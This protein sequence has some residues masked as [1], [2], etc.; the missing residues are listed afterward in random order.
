MTSATLAQSPGNKVLTVRQA[1]F[2][3]KTLGQKTPWPSA[4]NLI[5]ITLNSN[6]PLFGSEVRCVTNITIS[7]FDGACIS[8]DDLQVQGGIFSTVSWH[9]ETSSIL[10]RVAGAIGGPNAQ[11]I[12]FS[13]AATNP[14]EAQPSPLIEIQADGIPIPRSRMAKDSAIPTNSDDAGVGSPNGAIF[15]ASARDAEP[16][17]VHAPAFRVRNVGQSTP[18]PGANNT[19]GVTISPNVDI[20]VGSVMMIS[21]LTNTDG[22][23]AAPTGPISL[24]DGDTHP[25]GKS[26]LD[27]PAYFAASTGGA[28]GQGFWDQDEGTLTLY[29]VSRLT[30]GSFYSF[31]FILK[32]ALCAQDAQPVCIRARNLRVGC[33]VG[34]LIPR[35]RMNP[36]LTT[37]LPAFKAAQGDAAPLLVFQ[38]RIIVSS[39]IHSTPWPSVN[40][41]IT[42]TF[43]TNV[44]LLISAF[45][46]KITLSGLIQT[47]T[48]DTMSLA[49]TIQDGLGNV[50]SVSGEW[51]QGAGKLVFAPAEDMTAG[52]NYTISF[53][54]QNRHCQQDAPV[55]TAGISGACFP[56]AQM[57]AMPAT[58]CNVE[59][60]PLQVLG[61][62]CD[63]QSS[64]A[65]FTLKNI[66]QSTPYP[67]C[68]NTITVQVMMSIPLSYEQDAGIRIGFDT[69]MVIG[70]PG[71]DV[72]LGGDSRERFFGSLANET[73]KALWDSDDHILTLMV[74]QGQNLDPCVQY[75]ITFD[76]VNPLMV[77]PPGSAAASQAI[78]QEAETVHISAFSSLGEMIGASAMSVDT[79]SDLELPG[80]TILDRS[81]LRVHVPKFFVK[82]IGQSSPYPGGSNLLSV[83]I[84]ANVDLKSGSIIFIK[85]LDE[86]IAA[87]GDIALQ[88][89][90]ADFFQSL[91]GTGSHASWDDC[92]KALI[93]KV[94]T[95]LGCAGDNYTFAFEVMNPLEPQVCADVLINATEIANPAVFEDQGQP[96]KVSITQDQSYD[97]KSDGLAMALDEISLLEDID[98]AM[99]GDACPMTVWSAA[100]VVKDIG[101][102]NPYP[103][104]LNTLTAT[105]ATNVPIWASIQYPGRSVIKPSIIISEIVG[106]VRDDADATGE[107]VIKLSSTYT[108]QLVSEMSSQRYTNDTF[109]FTDQSGSLNNSATWQR[110]INR[111]AAHSQLVLYLNESSV[112]CC[113][114]GPKRL[115]VTFSFTVYNPAE[116]QSPSRAVSISAAGLPI[117]SSAMREGLDSA[118]PMHV[119]QASMT[120]AN[121]AQEHA[122]PCA[123]NTITVSLQTDIILYARCSPKILLTELTGLYESRLALTDVTTVETVNATRNESLLQWRVQ[124]T[125]IHPWQVDWLAGNLTRNHTRTMMRVQ[126]FCRLDETRTTCNQ[127]EG[128]KVGLQ[129][130][131]WYQDWSSWVYFDYTGPMPVDWHITLTEAGFTFAWEGEAHRI[132]KHPRNMQFAETQINLADVDDVTVT[133]CIE[134]P[135][136]RTS[137]TKR[138][139]IQAVNGGQPA[140]L[141]SFAIW[142]NE[143]LPDGDDFASLEVAI[144]A[145]EVPVDTVLI[146]QFSLD[147]PSD[148]TS[149]DFAPTAEITGIGM[150]NVTMQRPLDPERWPIT[151]GRAHFE[152]AEIVQSAP[153]P[154]AENTLSVTLATSSEIASTCNTR[155]IITGL[156]GACFASISGSGVVPL[157]GP[158]ANLF[159]YSLPSALNNSGHARALWDDEDKELSFFVAG[160]GLQGQIPYTFSIVVRNP[161]YAQLSPSINISATGIPIQQTA[162]LRNP[163]RIKPAGIF[164]AIPSE[165]EPLHVRGFGDATSFIVKKIGQSN[166]NPGESN[167]LTV[168][169]NMNLPLTSSSPASSITISGLRGAEAPDGPMA[170][171][172]NA[173]SFEGDWYDREKQLRLEVLAAT[174]PGQ[175]YIISFTVTNAKVA[176]SSPSVFIQTG[177]IVIQPAAMDTDDVGRLTTKDDLGNTVSTVE[178]ATAPLFILGPRLIKKFV[179]QT[180]GSAWPGQSNVLTF[181]FTPTVPLVPAPGGRSSVIISGLK[182]V[183]RQSGTVPIAGASAGKFTDCDTLNTTTCSAQQGAWD[184]VSQKLTLNVYSTL[185]AFEDLSISFSFDNA[186]EG[187]EPPDLQV[188][189]T[190]NNDADIRGLMRTEYNWTQQ[191]GG[192]HTV[193]SAQMD[194]YFVND[195]V[196][197]AQTAVDGLQD[198]STLEDGNVLTKTEG[199]GLKYEGILVIEEPGEYTFGVVGDDSTDLAVDGQV[200]ASRSDS[201]WDVT[202]AQGNPTSRTV[203]LGRGQHSFRA[204]CLQNEDGLGVKAYWK[205]PSASTAFVLIPDSAFRIEIDVLELP[206]QDFG[207]PTNVAGTDDMALLIYR[208]ASFNVKAIAQSTPIPGATNTITV[209]FQPQFPLTG[210]MNSTIT[211]SG[212]LGSV[213]PDATMALLDASALFNATAQWAAKTGTL[214]LR[215]SPG[216]TVPSDSVTVVKFDLD[217][218]TIPQTG[219]SMI[220]ISATGDVPISAASM[221]RGVGDESPLMVVASSF[222]V[223]SIGQSS[224]TPGAVNTITVTLQ[225]DIILSRSRGSTITL[226]G[227]K[228]SDTPS[229]A[230]LPLNIS[231]PDSGAP[232]FSSPMPDIAVSFSANCKLQDDK[233][234]LLDDSETDFTGAILYFNTPEPGPLNCSSRWTKV[235]SYDVSTRCA[236]LTVTSGSWTDGL[237]KCNNLGTVNR[238]EVVDGG[239]GYKSGAAIIG[240]GATG[241]GL[242]G[243]CAVDSDSGRILSVTLS[244]EGAGYTDDTTISCPAAC[245]MSTCG[246]AEIEAYGGHLALSMV[247]RYVTVSA[248]MWDQLSGTLEL[249]VHEELSTTSPT[250]FSFDVRNSFTPQGASEVW[251]MA[252]GQTPIGSTAMNGSTMLIEGTNSTATATCACAPSGSDSDCT[253]TTSFTDL[254][255]GRGVYALMAELQCNGAS[256]V[257]VKVNDVALDSDVVTQPPRACKDSCTNYHLLFE[258]RNVASSVDADGVLELSVD[259][260]SVATDYCGGG[261]NLKVLFTLY[262]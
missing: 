90:H 119:E 88:G 50:S 58:H 129:A 47:G 63:G 55:V 228:G 25:N 74:A 54:L 27:D 202:S 199:L 41:T 44:P 244:N 106:A 21:Q 185:N 241:S 247:Q 153:F 104:G 179:H 125:T 242:A 97:D 94:A 39:M 188:A 7:G 43:A 59:T 65:I 158:A 223:A 233:I 140:N 142:K 217:N 52:D 211:I 168:T 192:D 184:A 251:L 150:R 162:M 57:D 113:V 173:G 196:Q 139:A 24:F 239:T 108:S 261:D 3:A 214:T 182:G 98:G 240:D 226:H 238:V 161:P 20:D 183:D 45:A 133:S 180:G 28:A 194:A 67:G 207:V 12:T 117:T 258:W 248:G 198:S 222:T 4:A 46:P 234:E 81:P 231:T 51:D 8:G 195:M 152:R 166:A 17:L 159:D 145:S 86:A 260:S 11:P 121:I 26:T 15:D 18:Y 250:V 37:L 40:N 73:A 128:Y 34:G 33:E 13:F 60:E 118:A 144:T 257:V 205:T 197:V 243:V 191:D 62:P 176:Q 141:A 91:D 186:L 61:G 256:D 220:Q 164:G 209:S 120:L 71:G 42:V 236:T 189:V 181:S 69:G 151:V 148:P 230:A 204:R 93:L 99:P 154:F 22:T 109:L 216:E 5:T 127:G 201:T 80:T 169:L 254:P 178:G 102:S 76:V 208:S 85:E 115:R 135:T 107:A 172:T 38:P 212:L 96:S 100:F 171:T 6:V 101:Q 190:T 77:G 116:A 114:P 137:V 10:M 122:K 89:T 31:K 175:E 72:P 253:C 35:R 14:F 177:G 66:S 143:S 103:C 225:P 187:Q 156:D 252:G 138:L 131:P 167:V 78:L 193:S 213:T 132:F 112:E 75:N 84:S 70:L 87:P 82:N 163:N 95:D 227:I 235:D 259:A 9:P 200:V 1:A 64:S 224:S 174:T 237:A 206:P 49:L 53:E 262:Y 126:T 48:V 83:T 36:D 110:M 160:S 134:C 170:L 219:P 229:T 79:T 29:V 123:E 124:G 146:F 165:A 23:R 218:P 221:T 203:T 32:N 56:S 19:L 245:S 157:T 68:N 249:R 130:R 155:V 210:D 147:N 215:V 255:T 30:A 2:S 136:S 92:D 16:L 105:I 232:V 246:R 149:P 111:P